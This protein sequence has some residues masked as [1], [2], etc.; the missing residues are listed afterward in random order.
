MKT[1]SLFILLL[2]LVTLNFVWK[3]HIQSFLATFTE[4]LVELQP[5]N[6][7]LPVPDFSLFDLDGNVVR[8][9][10]YRGSAV[11][12]GFWAVW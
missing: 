2:A 10:D 7:R 11:L 5:I 4:S 8:L 9:G 6:S 1:K 12:I 3:N